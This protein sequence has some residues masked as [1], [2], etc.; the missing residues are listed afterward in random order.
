MLHR[1]AIIMTIVLAALFL[2]FVSCVM[3]SYGSPPALPSV[4]DPIEQVAVKTKV[5][6]RANR[7]DLDRIRWDV[8]GS[9]YLRDH[10]D[11]RWDHEFLRGTPRI[12]WK[13]DGQ[14][15]HSRGWHGIDGFIWQYRNMGGRFT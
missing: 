13:I 11:W 12:E 2:G 1:M 14:E 9:H 5:K 10:F 7:R 4:H 3:T 8:E 15:I 6:V